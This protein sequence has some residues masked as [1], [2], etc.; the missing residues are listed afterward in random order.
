LIK[1]IIKRFL[2]GERFPEYEKTLKYAYDIAKKY[3]DNSLELEN[4]INGLNSYI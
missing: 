1:E 4:L 3:V 2:R